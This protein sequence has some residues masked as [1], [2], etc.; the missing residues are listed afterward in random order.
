MN[1]HTDET[2]EGGCAC[3]H[4]R[5]RMESLPLIVHCCHCR[6]CQRETGAAFALNALI[7]SER[8]TVLEGEPEK[9]NTPSQSGKGQQ[10]VRC[11]HCKVAVWSHYAGGGTLTSFVRVGTLDDPGALAPDAHIFT[12]SKQPWL[13]LPEGTPAYDIFYE[14]ESFWRPDALARFAA[15][16][17]AIAAWKAGQT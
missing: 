6:W 10:I 9:V 4:V 1:Q 7:E 12:R 11:P 13:T 8:L 14:R 15:L 5:Y 17:P 2:F 3:R 16:G